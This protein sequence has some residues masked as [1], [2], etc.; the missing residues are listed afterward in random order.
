MAAA[1]LNSAKSGRYTAESAGLYPSPVDPG[2]VA[3][4]QERGVDLSCHRPQ[5]I[6]ACSNTAYD[7]IIFLS[8]SVR[9]GAHYI[10]HA[11]EVITL[12]IPVPGAKGPDGLDGYRELSRMLT[13]TIAEC[14]P[15]AGIGNDPC[16]KC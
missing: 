9:E 15:D 7:T 8:P 4:M 6:G 1:I 16:R 2:V 12:N 11:R 14:L 5:T 13:D 3:V 10:P